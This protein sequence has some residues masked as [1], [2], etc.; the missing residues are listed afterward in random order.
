MYG[1]LCSGSPSRLRRGAEVC[2]STTILSG[3]ASWLLFWLDCLGPAFRRRKT[4]DTSTLEVLV[5]VLL[6]GFL[7]LLISPIRPS[8]FLWDRQV[9][10]AIKAIAVKNQKNATAGRQP[11]PLEAVV[12]VDAAGGGGGSGGGEHRIGIQEARFETCVVLYPVKNRLLPSK[13]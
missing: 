8:F 13:L 10:V 5:L 7:Y 12:F 3:L 4:C 11:L 6:R 9:E 2:R 1:S